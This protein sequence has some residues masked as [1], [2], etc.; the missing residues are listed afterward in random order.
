MARYVALLRGI[1]VGGRR[2][3]PMG[4][5]RDLATDLGWSSVGTHLNSGNLIFSADARPVELITVLEQGIVDRF[6]FEAPVVIRD[7][8]QL[9]AALAANPFPDGDPKQVQFAFL[10]EAPTDGAAD[11]LATVASEVEQWDLSDEVLFVDFGG[12]L[13]RSKLAAGLD[14]ILG[15]VVTSRNLRTVQALAQML[16]EADETPGP[17]PA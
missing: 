12:G 3:V 13:A 16:A 7:T 1:N 11:R 5:L 6:G 17:P 8:D 2:K 9:R 4:D 15:T 10:A 14:R